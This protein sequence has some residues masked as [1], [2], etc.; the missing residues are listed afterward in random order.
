MDDDKFQTSLTLQPGTSLQ[1]GT[2]TILRTIGQ[3][4]FGITYQARQNSLNRI[5]CIKEYFLSG[6]CLRNTQTRNVSVTETSGDI[7]EKYRQSF[8]NEAQ[9]VATLNHPNIIDVIN[10]F[11]ENGTSYM[12]MPFIEGH[13]LEWIVKTQGPLAY[14]EAINYIA[15]VCNAVE[16]I[17]QRHILHRDIKPSNI[18]ITN[19][20][21]AILID[22]GSAREFI[23]DK[24][25]AHTSILTHGYA[26]PEQYSRVSRKG[27]YSDI[28]SLGATFYY[29]LTAKDPTDSA[30]RMT[31]IMPEP[32]ELNHSIPI[33]AN[34]VIMKAM[35]L[36]PTNRHQSAKEFM[37][38][39][40][41]R[42][43]SR[44]ATSTTPIERV[45]QAKPAPASVER[46]ENK[47]RA[48]F[49]F[50]I[51]L[52]IVGIIVIYGYLFNHGDVMNEKRVEH[53]SRV[54]DND[55]SVDVSVRNVVREYATA[56]DNNDFATLEK[57]Y[58]PTVER[59]HN[60]RNESA[61]QVVDRHRKYDD[62]FGVITKSTVVK[63]NT[64]SYNRLGN[65]RIDVTWQE[66]YYLSATKTKNSYF[67]LEKHAILN[68]NYKIVSIYDKQLER[69]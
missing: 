33:V 59:Y 6:R 10:V 39:I 45:T 47:S 34:R 21:R 13:T 37:D 8:V 23:D 69:Y 53:I 56:F 27:A 49:W 22:F 36:K 61:M 15:Q 41:N 1:G 55:V 62:M 5:V 31:E 60:A 28:Y 65:G 67:L 51:V 40:L 19:D 46:S 54:E 9:T 26:P 48:V 57:L 11:D 32:V 35:D 64:I 7:F 20:H 29:A 4:G 42:G 18:M 12:V 16:Y 24:T 66:E 52:F 30:A 38:D 17:H 63:W 50:M 68:S 43:L 3:G 2:Y 25:Q 44:P 14:E 58:A